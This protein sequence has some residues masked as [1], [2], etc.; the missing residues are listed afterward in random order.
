MGHGARRGAGAAAI[1]AGVEQMLGQVGS[2]V[3]SE[4][5]VWLGDLVEEIFVDD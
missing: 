3:G 4:C 5:S 1:G 2:G